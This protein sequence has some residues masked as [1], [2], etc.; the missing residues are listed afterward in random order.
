MDPNGH[1]SKGALVPTLPEQ[2]MVQTVVKVGNSGVIYEKVL[3]FEL[4]LCIILNMVELQ[5]KTE[6]QIAVSVFHY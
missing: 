5:S 4:A 3:Q 1:S 2:I 6:G